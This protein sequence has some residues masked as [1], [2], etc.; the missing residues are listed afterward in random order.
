MAFAASSTTE[1]IRV[2]STSSVVLCEVFEGFGF[3][4]FRNLTQM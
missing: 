2:H 4:L 3:A 1:M